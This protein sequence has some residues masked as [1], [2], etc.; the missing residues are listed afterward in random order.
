G[1]R[2]HLPAD[3]DGFIARARRVARTPLA[4]GFGISTREQVATVGRLADGVI[5][6]SALIAAVSAAADPPAAAHA[7]IR[8]LR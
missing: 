7:F 2:D 1:V 3:L 6:G 4:V 5:V 8:Q